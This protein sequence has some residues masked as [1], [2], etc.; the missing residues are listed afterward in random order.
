LSAGKWAAAAAARVLIDFV[1][2]MVEQER[3]RSRRGTAA[4][5]PG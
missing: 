1:R 3:E 2:K 4:R 5:R